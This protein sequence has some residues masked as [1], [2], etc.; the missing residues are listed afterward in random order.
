MQ[1][2]LHTSCHEGYDT[3]LKAD[4][5][6]TSLRQLAQTFVNWARQNPEYW[7]YTPSE[8]MLLAFT[9]AYPCIG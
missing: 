4:L 8:G 6:N 3:P 1:M 5:S 9:E 7:S 2:M